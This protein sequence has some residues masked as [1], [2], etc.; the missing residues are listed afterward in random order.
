LDQAARSGP[1]AAGSHPCRWRW[2]RRTMRRVR[3]VSLGQA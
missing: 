1:V 3:M 2:L